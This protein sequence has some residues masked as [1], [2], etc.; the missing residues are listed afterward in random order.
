MNTPDWS[1]ATL[2]LIETAIDED[3][4]P[5]GHDLT[6]GLLNNGDQPAEALVVP[7]ETGVIAGLALGPAIVRAF[8]RRLGSQIEF[9]AV[10]ADGDVVK[11]GVS[12]ATLRGS[13]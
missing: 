6:S 9:V 10:A 13:I 4:G 2:R 8:G 1:A 5:D 11:P 7:R 3:L 12:V